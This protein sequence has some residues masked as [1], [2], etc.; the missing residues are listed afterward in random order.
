MATA[1][2]TLFILE[3]ILPLVFVAFTTALVW[4]QVTWVTGLFVMAVLWIILAGFA[5]WIRRTVY[6][7]MGH[8]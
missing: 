5:H 1:L 4:K 6:Q 8:G 7:S 2:V 3:A